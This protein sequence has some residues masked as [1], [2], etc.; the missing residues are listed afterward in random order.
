MEGIVTE[1]AARRVSP[2]LYL[3]AALCFLLPF[4]TVSCN[5]ERAKPL[6]DAA[7]QSASGGAVP[8]TKQLNAC[9]DA[10]SG[11]TFASYS[12]LNLVAGSDPSVSSARVDACPGNQG[13]G[14]PS[15]GDENIGPQS[16]DGAALAV[17]I[18]ALL[19]G[20]V[21][22][23]R[24]GLVVAILSGV[25]IV[26]VSLNQNRLQTLVSDRATA[27]IQARAGSG[28]PLASAFGNISEFFRVSPAPGF[29]LVVAILGVAAL[30]NSAATI[31]GDPRPAR[32]SPPGSAPGGLPEP[33]S[34]YPPWQE[35]LRARSPSPPGE[36]PGQGPRRGEG[37]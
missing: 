34:A 15:G 12:G 25:A 32:M 21:S 11:R 22:F 3:V 17:I 18:L 31:I 8:D 6:V 35:R 20:M 16:L 28:N 33:D 36:A 24:R 14:T 2:V 37:D 10:L 29:W 9:L 1:S 5:T 26:L 4:A 7:V 30:Y 23:R 19:F 13:T 27:S